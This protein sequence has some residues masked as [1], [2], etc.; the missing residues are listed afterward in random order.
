MFGRIAAWSARHARVLLAVTVVVAAGAAF[1]ASRLDTDAGTDTLV[2]RDS[3]T[4]Q[5]TERFRRLFGDDAVVV[6]VEGDL[7]RLVLTENLGKLLRLEG[8]LSGNVPEGV[9]PLPGA[10]TELAEF[11]PAKVVYGP[12][13]FLNQAA[14]GI[15]AALGGQIQQMQTQAVREGRAA[16][17][18][19]AEQ[20]LSE[21][22]QRQAAQAAADAVARRFQA[23]LLEVA[24]EYGITRLPQLDDPLFVSQVVFDNRQEPGTPKARFSYLFPN[25]D[26]ALISIRLRPGLGEE[27]RGRALA[28]IREAVYDTTPRQVCRNKPCFTLSGGSYVVS[29]APAVIDGVASQL[30]TALIVLFAAAILVMAATLTI[31]FQSRMRLLP[32]GLALAAAAITFG[33][34]GLLGGSLT[35]AA[36]AVLPILIGL[37]VDYAIQLQARFDEAQASG[38][39]GGE[40]ARLAAARAGPVVGTACLATAAGFCV[41]LLSPVPMVRG[42]GLMLVGGVAIAFA[43]ALTAGFAALSLRAGETGGASAGG[44][45]AGRA[46]GGG[47][48]GGAGG[49][50]PARAAARGGRPEVGSAADREARTRG[51][52]AGDRTRGLA[53]RATA[54]RDRAGSRLSAFGTEALA[55]SIRSPGRVLAVAGA[56]ALC[57]WLVAPRVPIESDFTRLVPQDLPEVRDLR[58]LQEV[59]GVSG[60]LDVTVRADDL[61]DPEL[62]EWMAGFKERVLSEHGFRGKFPSCR[63]A[64]VCPGASP[65]DFFTDPEAELTRQRIQALYA[66]IPPYDRQAVLS[67]DDE[68]RIGDTANLSFGIRTMPLDRQQELIDEIRAAVDPPG[69][70]TGPP[71]GTEVRLAGLPVLAAESNTSLASSRYWLTLAGL[72]AVALALLAVYRSPARVAVPLIP[73]VMATGWASLVLFASHIELNPMSATLGALVIA[74]ATEFSVILASRYREERESGRSL[75]EALRRAYA[76]TGAAVLASGLTAIAGFATLVVTA[77]PGLGDYD[78]PMLR[79]FG[80]VTVVDLGVALLGVMLVLPAA[81][82][83]AEEG[84]ELGRLRLAGRRPLARPATSERE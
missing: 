40:A 24:S 83:W 8:C 19:A 69:E 10:C 29:G 56:L 51:V 60:E 18:Q 75:G 37:A 35:I 81:L 66:A 30:K 16:A 12:A 34:T 21:A 28:L 41:L 78:F 15:Q 17:R 77:I 65:T 39:R 38:A 79:D 45:S 32:L 48:A 80:L 67:Q 76:R 4:F 14:L 7:R 59:T 42:F 84:V 70:G 31:V 23:R 49:G 82:V 54:L 62:I 55:V 57:G 47:S 26:S 1:G 11:R 74:I 27:E 5:A 36:I 13:T 63:E 43:L 53:A 72:L 6:L 3:E 73:I 46:A 64:E 2:D 52:L 68:G 33:L 58:R 25:R 22:E 61:T 71:A 50:D 44:A 9:D 20:G